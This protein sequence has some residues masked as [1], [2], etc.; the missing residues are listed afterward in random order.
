MRISNNLFTCLLLL[1]V[2]L[3]GLVSA[4]NTP[5]NS[6]QTGETQA[7]ITGRVNYPSTRNVILEDFENATARLIPVR[8]DGF[9][10]KVP[11]GRYRIR[12][13]LGISVRFE[14]QPASFEVR[15]GERLNYLVPALWASPWQVNHRGWLS[16][17]LWLTNFLPYGRDVVFNG[18]KKRRV[19]IKSIWTGPFICFDGKWVAGS[20]GIFDHKTNRVTLMRRLKDQAPVVFIDRDGKR[21]EGDVAVIDLVSGQIV[22]IKR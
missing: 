14:L 19:G 11:P 18:L 9:E 16:E 10:V 8:D 2:A 6:P 3:G 1:Q 13:V 20:L 5:G 7:T 4:Q 22:S 21:L 15:A 12:E 17:T